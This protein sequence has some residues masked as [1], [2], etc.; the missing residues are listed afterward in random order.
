MGERESRAPTGSPF[1]AELFRGRT[2]QRKDCFAVL[3]RTK[4]FIL[5]SQVIKQV[6][7]KGTTV[8]GN[9]SLIFLIASTGKIEGGE[10]ETLNV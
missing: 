6:V 7:F 3:C 8:F 5:H 10:S 9:V 4:D 2:L 1:A